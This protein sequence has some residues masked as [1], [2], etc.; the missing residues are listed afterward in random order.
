MR[1]NSPAMRSVAEALGR[2]LELIAPVPAEIVPISEAAGRVLREDLAA[3]VAH[4]GVAV[5]AMDG[6]AVRSEDAQSGSRLRVVATLPA[7]RLIPLCLK[8]GECARLFTGSA[9]PEGADA[10]AIQENVDVEGTTMIL[11][12]DTPRG[13]FVR[14][15]G[16]DFKKG[17][18]LL[19]APRRLTPEDIALAAAMNIPQVRVAR[20]PRVLVLPTGD[21]LVLPGIEP[22][23]GEVVASTGFGLSAL[24]SRR[25]AEIILLPPV[26]DDV[27]AIREQLHSSEVELVT[28]LGGAS[29]GDRDFVGRVLARE[30]LKLAFHGVAMRPGKPTLAGRLSGTPFVGLPGNPVSAMV[31]GHVFLLPAIDAAL[32]LAAGPRPRNSARLGRELPPG[33]QREHYMRARVETF[34]GDVTCTPFSTQDSSVLRD[35]ARANA[36]AIHPAGAPARKAGQEIEYIEILS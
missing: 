21:E 27:S 19:R 6:Y 15:A 22:K 33:S 25:G 13:R 20:R 29:V 3:A 18:I 7:G 34:S 24:L 5:S 11:R 2:I 4:P 31:C 32:G 8:P 1:P 10:I 26:E 23:P 30:D 17:E 35:L 28:T 16:L 12:E 9:V 36:L 14:P